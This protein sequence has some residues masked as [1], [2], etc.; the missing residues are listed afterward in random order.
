M[1][2]PKATIEHFGWDEAFDVLG[3][4]GVEIEGRR[5]MRSK[6]GSTRK[7]L[8]AGTPI[9]LC[10]KP[11]G[12]RWVRTQVFTLRISSHVTNRDLAE[13]VHFARKPVGWMEARD[14]R[15]LSWDEWEGYYQGT[16]NPFAPWHR[17]KAG[18]DASAVV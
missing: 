4:D 3:P 12:S 7:F 14:G 5:Y 9:R 2:A 18:R 11:L 16:S 17:S 10:S 6:G 15:R 13:L 1:R 8:N